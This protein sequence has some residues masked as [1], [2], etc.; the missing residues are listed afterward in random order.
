MLLEVEKICGNTLG[1][2][3]ETNRNALGPRIYLN[4]NE[5]IIDE[6]IYV[7]KNALFIS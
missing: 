1:N 4:F 5:I 2:T 7:V 6:E 3:G